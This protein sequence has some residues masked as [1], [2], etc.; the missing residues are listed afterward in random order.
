MKQAARDGRFHAEE[1]FVL[2]V[3]GIGPELAV[4]EAD[5]LL[6][7]LLGCISRALLGEGLIASCLEICT[8]A[9]IMA[10]FVPVAIVMDVSMRPVVGLVVRLVVGATVVLS[11]G[12]ITRCISRPGVSFTEGSIRPAPLIEGITVFGCCRHGTGSEQ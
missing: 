6:E 7:G 5:F 9:R 8:T 2:G 12:A 4:R 10:I 1:G 3:R 11:T